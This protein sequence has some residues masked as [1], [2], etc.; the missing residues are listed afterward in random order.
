MIM[1]RVFHSLLKSLVNT[2]LVLSLHM[3]QFICT[4]AVVCYC[5]FKV[6][7]N[8]NASEVLK[9]IAHMDNSN[10]QCKYI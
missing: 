1:T 6:H 4:I 3:R 10:K 5:R 7:R 9:S 2:A 8:G